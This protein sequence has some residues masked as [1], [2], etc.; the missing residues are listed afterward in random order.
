M[1]RIFFLAVSFSSIFFASSSAQMP[2]PAVFQKK[3]PSIF[4]AVFTTNK[5]SFTIEANRSWSP[6][7]VD[8]LYQL[9]S[10]GFYNNNRL[11]RVEPFFVVQFG[12]SDKPAINDFWIKKVLAD[13]PVMIPNKKGFLSFARG[14]R[15]SRSTQLFINMVDNPLLDTVLRETVKGY[16]PVARIIKGMETLSLLN[17]HYGKKPLFL[18]DSLLKYGNSYFEQKFPGLDYII[19][20]RI[21]Q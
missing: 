15:N 7:G 13:E 11:F 1:R 10:S 16:P 19:S 12:I 2:S 21:V 4:R 3:A 8:R 5:G 18:Q 17:S 20:A 6:G 9:I 14:A